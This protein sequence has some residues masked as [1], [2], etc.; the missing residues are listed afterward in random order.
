MKKIFL[1]LMAFF[2]PYV[3]SHAVLLPNQAKSGSYHRAAIKIGHGCN[4]SATTKIVIEIPESVHMAKPMPKPGWEIEIVRAKLAEPYDS[5][6]KLLTEDVRQLIW[7][8]GNIP[9]DYYD[10]FVFHMKLP[11]SAGKI[12]FPV[13]QTCTDGENYWKEIPDAHDG[14]AG[15]SA[16][17]APV[18]EL[19]DNPEK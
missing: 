6:G 14:H 10:E 5:H 8:G 16:F 19:T 13:K 4:G 15:H 18:L 12:Y 7:Y 3:F 9:D 11:E 1:L 17:P 2:P